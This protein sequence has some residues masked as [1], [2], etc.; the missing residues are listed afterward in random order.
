[1]MIKRATFESW[2]HGIQTGQRFVF[3]QD[4]SIDIGYMRFVLVNI[5]GNGNVTVNWS[6]MNSVDDLPL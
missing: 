1:M 5:S 2:P 4:Q 6:T 3:V